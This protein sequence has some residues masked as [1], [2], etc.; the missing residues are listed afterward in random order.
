MNV[1]VLSNS[2]NISEKFLKL[3]DDLRSVCVTESVIINTNQVFDNYEGTK[4]DTLLPRYFIH[5]RLA[6]SH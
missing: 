6:N 2:Y 4:R 5:C 1:S 3:S